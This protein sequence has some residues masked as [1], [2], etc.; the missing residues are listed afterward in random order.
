MTPTQ[1]TQEVIKTFERVT[2]DLPNEDHDEVIKAIIENLYANA[3]LIAEPQHGI[4]I[5]V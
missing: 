3:I 1:A 5:M 4:C 2:D